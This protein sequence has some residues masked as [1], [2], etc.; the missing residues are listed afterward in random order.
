VEKNLEC[1]T[2][3]EYNVLKKI[4]EKDDELIVPRASFALRK[5]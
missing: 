5:N 4:P 3:S 1:G 2:K